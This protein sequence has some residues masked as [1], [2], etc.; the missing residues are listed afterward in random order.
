[1]RFQPLNKIGKRVAFKTI[2]ALIWILTKIV[3]VLKPKN[4][5]WYDDERGY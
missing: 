2:A 4:D 3:N 5:G 1:M